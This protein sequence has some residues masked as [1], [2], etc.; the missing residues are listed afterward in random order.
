MSFREVVLKTEI[1]VENCGSPFCVI[2]AEEK[3]DKIMEIAEKISML[4]P[5]GNSVILNGWDGDYCVQLKP[6]EVFRVFSQDK[7]VFVQTEKETLLLKMRLYEFEEI[8]EKCGWSNFIRI[9]NTDIVNFDNASRF[10]MSLSG[11]IKI[12]LKNDE[13][14]FVS[15][16]YMN[17]IRG[18]L[19]L[20]K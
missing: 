13:C 14:A 7:K 9:S 20:K 12:I 11:I 5:D 8:I 2:H 1:K 4:D 10:D 16:R 18:V 6:A 19:C 15:R 17:K 3:T